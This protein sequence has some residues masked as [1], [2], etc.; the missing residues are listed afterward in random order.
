[1]FEELRTELI[2]EIL[3]VVDSIPVPRSRTQ[4][5]Y[6]TGF[7][8]ALSAVKYAIAEKYDLEK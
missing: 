8:N 3:S 4:S 1:M 7:E 5:R 2:K 6:T